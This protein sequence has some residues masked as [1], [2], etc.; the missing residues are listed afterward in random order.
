[1]VGTSSNGFQPENEVGKDSTLGRYNDKLKRYLLNNIVFCCIACFVLKIDVE[2][3]TN[4][5]VFLR[6]MI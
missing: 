6:F 2:R 1:M 4:K 3:E 5:N